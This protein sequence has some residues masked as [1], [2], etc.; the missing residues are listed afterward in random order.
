M[1]YQRSGQSAYVARSIEERFFRFLSTPRRH[2]IGFGVNICHY[3]ALMRAS[4]IY[5]QGLADIGS[6]R[7]SRIN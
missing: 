5:C 4:S 6:N 2:V 3:P 7:M 1:P